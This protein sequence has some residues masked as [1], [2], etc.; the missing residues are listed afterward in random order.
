MF[1]ITFDAFK[2]SALHCISNTFS[3]PFVF[4][5]LKNK[6]DQKYNAEIDQ[7]IIFFPSGSRTYLYSLF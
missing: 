4:F 2:S 6:N 1:K 7:P 5:I 3:D